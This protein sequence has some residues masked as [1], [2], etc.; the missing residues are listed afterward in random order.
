MS[1]GTK[2][3]GAQVLY[4]ESDPEKVGNC[5]VVHWRRVV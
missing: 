3:G 4:K 1:I 5:S 2:G